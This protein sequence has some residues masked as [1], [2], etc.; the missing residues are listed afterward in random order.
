MALN[1]YATQQ[2]AFKQ[3]RHI[4]ELFCSQAA[5]AIGFSD[6]AAGR[7]HA[8]LSR[9]LIGQ[10]IGIVMERYGIDETRAHAF[11]V[12][13]SRD[14]NIKLR[15]IAAGIVSQ[16]NERSPDHRREP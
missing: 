10:A 9:G 13:A 3:S 4:A 15:D 1:L 11:L 5:I 7:Q 12:R 8:L 2:D 16:L 14:G 6:T